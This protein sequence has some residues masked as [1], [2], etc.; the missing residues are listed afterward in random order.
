MNSDMSM[1]IMAS[2]VSNRNSKRA[3]CTA[4]VLPTPVGPKNRN[5]PL[6]RRAC[7]PTARRANVG[8]RPRRCVPPRPDRPRAFPAPPPCAAASP[9]HPAASSTPGCRLHFGDHFGDLLFGDL[10]AHQRR[11][12]LLRGAGKV[13]ALLE[14]GDPA[15]LQLRHARQAAGAARGFELSAGAIELLADLRRARVAAFSAFQTSSRSAYS[16][17]PGRAG[18]LGGSPRR[19]RVASSFSFFSA[20]CSI[21]S[22]MMRRSS[23]SSASGL[24]SDLHADACG[25]LVDQIDRLVGQ[26]AVGNVTV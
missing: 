13:Q 21:F 18:C 16:P 10:V 23:L 15:V 8:S 2:S 26:L 6:G 9:S 7:H 1:R 17:S 5:E 14:L 25:R 11:R 12:L 22:W 19:L 24:E 4:S 20:T 3:P